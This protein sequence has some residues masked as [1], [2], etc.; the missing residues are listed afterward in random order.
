MISTVTNSISK[1]LKTL[2]KSLDDIVEA[3]RNLKGNLK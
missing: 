1:F 3:Y 2:G